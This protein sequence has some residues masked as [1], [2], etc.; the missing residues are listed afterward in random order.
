M[1]STRRSPGA[2]AKDADVRTAR[3]GKP[4]A[5]WVDTKDDGETPA[6]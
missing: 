6:T 5:S 4:W 3:D 2:S 1:A